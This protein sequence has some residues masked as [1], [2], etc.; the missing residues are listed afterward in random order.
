MFIIYVYTTG[1]NYNNELKLVLTQNT[2]FAQIPVVVS[3]IS[4]TFVFCV[5]TISRTH[6]MSRSIPDGRSVLGESSTLVHHLYL[7]RLCC[8]NTRLLG[9]FAFKRFLFLFLKRIAIDVIPVV[10]Q[11]NVVPSFKLNSWLWLSALST[12][13]LIHCSVLYFG[14]ECIFKRICIWLKLLLI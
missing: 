9:L 4:R 2:T 13:V 3:L 14:V 10:T 8:L 7:K 5:W 12:D 6:A 11:C 1:V